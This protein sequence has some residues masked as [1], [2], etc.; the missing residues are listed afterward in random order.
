MAGSTTV[1]GGAEAE[2]WLHPDMGYGTQ[3]GYFGVIPPTVPCIIR[4]NSSDRAGG[5]VINKL[6]QKLPCALGFPEKTHTVGLLRRP[7]ECKEW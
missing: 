3:G 5:G 4:W 1:A 2:I 6:W 7:A